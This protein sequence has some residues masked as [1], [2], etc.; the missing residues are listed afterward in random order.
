MRGTREL[1]EILCKMGIPHFSDYWGY[2]V[3]HDWP[4]WRK[5]LPYFFEKFIIK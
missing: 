3:N 2:D 1:D 4:W 5:Q